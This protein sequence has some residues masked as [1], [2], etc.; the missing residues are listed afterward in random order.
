MWKETRYFEREENFE[1][2][3]YITDGDKKIYCRVIRLTPQEWERGHALQFQIFEKFCWVIQASPKDGSVLLPNGTRKVYD[4]WF[5]TNHSGQ[6]SVFTTDQELLLAILVDGGIKESLAN[7]IIDGLNHACIVSIP[8][9][10]EQY[11]PEMVEF[12]RKHNSFPEKK[13]QEKISNLV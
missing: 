4:K 11:F 8:E 12:L 3:K 10:M 9:V 5:Y 7:V 13:I 1:P 6:P 2:D